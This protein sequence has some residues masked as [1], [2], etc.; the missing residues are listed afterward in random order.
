MGPDPGS[1]SR[2]TSSQRAS[3]GTARLSGCD[4]RTLLR[5]HP[6]GQGPGTIGCIGIVGDGAVQRRFRDDMLEEIRRNG[7][8]F[9]LKV[10]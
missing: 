3:C 6:D 5:I 8:S 4:T 7:G 9:T 2:G 1:G 10:G